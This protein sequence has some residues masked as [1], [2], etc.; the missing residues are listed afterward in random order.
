MAIRVLVLLIVSFSI[1]ANELPARIVDVG[2]GLCV[3]IFCGS[4]FLKFY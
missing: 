4:N 2:A 3:V 1:N